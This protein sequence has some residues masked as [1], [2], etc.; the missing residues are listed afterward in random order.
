VTGET[1]AAAA[2]AHGTNCLFEQTWWLDLTAPGRWGEAVV[3]AGQETVGRWRYVREEV[4]GVQVLCMP[5][6][7]QTL[8]PWVHTRRTH[9][10]KVLGERMEIVGALLDQ[11]PPH[12]LFVQNAHHSQWDVLPPHWRGYRSSVRVTYVLDELGDQDRLWHGMLGNVRTQIRKAR[13]HFEI[14]RGA[15]PGELT[16]LHRA[17]FARQKLA[18]PWPLSTVEAVVTGAQRHGRGRLLHAVDASG[19]TRAAV[20][21]V[22]DDRAM[23]YLLSGSDETARRH[24]AV[25]LLL[26]EAIRLASGVCASFDFEGSMLPGVEW[27]FRGFG[28]RQV[29]YCQLWR[30]NGKAEALASPGELAPETFSRLRAA[31]VARA[32]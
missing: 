31:A 8:G 18:V 14:R 13:D 10:A 11:L 9:R 23:Y 7:T 24:G 1:A 15:D 30:S 26:W 2:V 5:Q 4:A 32:P 27:M 22:W 16:R 25:A 19:T 28:G 17:T 12:D 3:G 6:L 21:V 20:F 29:P